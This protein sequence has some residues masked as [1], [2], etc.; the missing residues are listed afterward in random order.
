M[1]DIFV[2]SD[3]H[4][5]HGGMLTFLGYDGRPLRPFGSIQ[6]MD[7][8]I[9]ETHNQV[10]R[11]SDKFYCLGDVAMARKDIQVAG[12]LNGHRRLCRG[13]HDI[14]PTKWYLPFFEEIYA[15]R[16]IAPAQEGGVTLLLS[17][18]PVHPAGL[19]PGWVNVHGHVHRNVPPG[20]YGP[21][22][23]NVSLEVLDYR[24]RSIEELRVMG[25]KQ[26]AE[27]M[28]TNRSAQ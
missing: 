4:F 14:Y 15:T 27:V 7:A 6:E 5:G 21:S 1:A 16:Y 26:L 17:H 11:P 24:P 25:R 23:L 18:Y 2:S 8:A 12:G 20:F 28:G 9:I 3:P 10:V 19:K 22:Y 13:N